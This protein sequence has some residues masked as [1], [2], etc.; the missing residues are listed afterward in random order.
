MNAQGS[1]RP[2]WRRVV[3]FNLLAGIVLGIAGFYLGRATAVLSAVLV[4]SLVLFFQAVQ[5]LGVAA[6]LRPDILLT[7]VPWGGFLILTGWVTLTPL[8]S[9][10]V[11]L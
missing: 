7:L 3:G 9:V 1:A 10:A 2:L 5:G 8:V 4:V 11:T 6:G